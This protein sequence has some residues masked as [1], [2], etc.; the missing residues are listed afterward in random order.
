M[1]LGFVEL[2]H[3]PLRTLGKATIFQEICH[4]VPHSG[5]CLWATKFSEQSKV[6]VIDKSNPPASG[7]ACEASA[8]EDN[9]TTVEKETTTTTEAEVSASSVPVQGEPKPEPGHVVLEGSREDSHP[10]V[11]TGEQDKTKDEERTDV[12]TVAQTGDTSENQPDTKHTEDQ[13]KET[14][15]TKPDWSWKPQPPPPP[16]FDDYDEDEDDW[17]N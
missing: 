12:G 13:L 5:P 11:L 15:K 7:A 16:L 3:V 6:Q 2:C 8:S 17:L 1:S 10:E 4:I 14:P 9:S